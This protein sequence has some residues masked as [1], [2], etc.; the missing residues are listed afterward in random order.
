MKLGRIKQPPG[1]WH[2]PVAPGVELKAMSETILIQQIHEYRLRNNIPPGDIERDIDIFYCTKYPEACQKEAKDYAPHLGLPKDP[3]REPLLNRVTR[4]VT[5]LFARQPRG[6]FKL[7][8][9]KTATSRAL[10]CAGCPGNKPWR[11][12]CLGC[13]SNVATLLLQIRQLR[14]T[15]QDSLL[16]ACN[17]AGWGNDAAVHMPVDELNLTA[18]Q[19]A[20]LPSRCWRKAA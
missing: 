14:K 7:E 11:S 19:I 17:F 1:G 10:I 12:G 20:D 18:D 3:P 15:P 2:Y 9:A 6:G 8:D 13:S 16:Y 5:T 4:W